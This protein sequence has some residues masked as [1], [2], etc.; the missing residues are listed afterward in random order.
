MTGSGKRYT[1]VFLSVCVHID[2]LPVNNSPGVCA[3]KY[4]S[5][6]ICVCVHH[7]ISCFHS[8]PIFHMCLLLVSG[9]H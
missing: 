7:M 3:G 2:C 8:F 6:Y 9:R 1:S 5:I 4:V